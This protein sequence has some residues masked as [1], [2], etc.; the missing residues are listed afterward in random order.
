VSR[1]KGC[2]F[3]SLH[4]VLTP[5]NDRFAHGRFASPLSAQA[6]YNLGYLYQFGIGLPNPD[7]ALA[8]RYYDMVKEESE[9]AAAV[10]LRS[11]HWGEKWSEFKLW[12]RGE[13]DF[14]RRKRKEEK[15]KEEKKKKGYTFI[16]RGSELAIAIE[17]FQ[18]CVKWTG[19]FVTQ[20]LDKV[21]V[22]WS[23]GRSKRTVRTPN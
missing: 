6:S 5:F 12:W 11:L 7:Y 21:R 1:Q 10:A 19:E 4:R 18:N 23:R 9:F 14:G 13:G 17:G 16:K 20:F 22:G 8:K 2:S 15:K 3:L